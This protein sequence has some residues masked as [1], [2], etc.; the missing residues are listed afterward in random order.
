MET[1]VQRKTNSPDFSTAYFFLEGLTELGIEYLFCN[2]GT[3]HA[4]IIEEF[5]NRRKRGEALPRDRTLSAREHRRPHGGRLC[6][7]DRSRTGS[8]RA[9]GR[10]HRQHRHRHA[11]YLPQPPAG[12]AHGRQGAVHG[13]RRACR[14][15]RHLRAF[16]AR[17]DRPGQPRASLRQMGMDAALRHR[18]Q[19]GVA[20]RPLHH[21]ERAARPGLSDDA[22]RDPDAN[23][24][25]RRSAQF[26]RRA[27]RQHGRQRRRSRAY[28]GARRPSHQGRASDPD[29]R[30][31]RPQRARGAAQCGTCRSSPASPHSKDNATTNISHASPCFLGFQPGKHVPKAD[32]GL[33]V[34][35][36]VP[37]FP[38]DVQANPDTFWAHIDVDILKP[39][40]PMWT[41]PGN[42]R[43]Q[44]DIRSHPR[45]T[46]GRS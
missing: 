1:N 28:S 27:V 38:S 45:T 24:E 40:S 21:A 2:F 36:D 25:R 31:C 17:A 42:M 9:R 34:D 30:L 4:P 46:A 7:R 43:M 6:L 32:V 5:A 26:F 39:A 23:L 20:A 19:G 37:W 22:A 18:G 16:R 12:A 11:Q 44:G 10:R 33:L 14:H 15:A 13:R 3:D 35:V 41:F 8:A 29:H